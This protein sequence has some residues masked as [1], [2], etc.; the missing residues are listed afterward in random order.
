MKRQWKAL[1]LAVMLYCFGPAYAQDTSQP[2]RIIVSFAAGG[3]VD[4]LARAM[5]QEMSKGLGR[6]VIV[7]N[8]VGGGGVIGTAALA[9]AAP[10]GNTIGIIISSHAVNPG[11]H[12]SLPY[13]S[14][15]DFT[16]ISTLVRMPITIAVLPSHPAKDFGELL[17]IAKREPGTQTY[18]SPGIGTAGHLTGA[19]SALEGK[20]ELQHVP[21][22]GGA[23]SMQDLLAG[24]ISMSMHNTNSIDPVVKA[25]KVRILA[26]SSKDRA[27]SL[28][29]V[30]AISEYLPGFDVVEWYGMA[31]PKGMSPETTEKLAQEIARV[32]DI[33]SK[34]KRFSVQEGM[35]LAASTPAEFRAFL[36]A[37]LK[38][39]PPLVRKLG[40]KAE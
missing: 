5:S 1:A 25:G 22:R 14:E 23:P 32:L 13:D 24:H 20:V 3:T 38:R 27:P 21:Y 16:P 34:E 8:R 39:W 2:L 35:V 12:E 36:D 28:P 4:V 19:L 26:V 33:L 11:L 7:E 37:E 15:K 29:D 31:G 9:Q 10:D 17:E 6:T 18:G 40:F 30:P